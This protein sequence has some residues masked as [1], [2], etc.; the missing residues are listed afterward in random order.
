MHGHGCDASLIGERSVRLH[1][2]TGS[3]QEAII[4]DIQR[5]GLSRRRCSQ[6]IPVRMA[7]LATRAFVQWCMHAGPRHTGAM[8]VHRRCFRN[9]DKTRTS[10]RR[11]DVRSQ[12][13]WVAI[14]RGAFGFRA[15][16]IG[17]ACLIESKTHIV[18]VN[19]WGGCVRVCV[20][21]CGEE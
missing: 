20:C 6:R 15:A 17:G 3:F 14:L 12:D 19:V 4:N 16:Q 21:V 5:L 9:L 7:L 1:T 8:W 11:L 2:L 13:I 10:M 18:K